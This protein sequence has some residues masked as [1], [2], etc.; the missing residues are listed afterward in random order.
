MAE[1]DPNK[2]A[3]FLDSIR[4]PRKTFLVVKQDT[5]LQATG[6]IVQAQDVEDAKALVNEGFYMEETKAEVLDTLE[7]VIVDVTEI[8]EK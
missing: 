8:G 2:F 7:S 5:V 4:P 3:R 6:Y 1:I